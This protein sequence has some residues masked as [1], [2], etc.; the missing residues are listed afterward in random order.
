M[1]TNLSYNFFFKYLIDS[2]ICKKKELEDITVEIKDSKPGHWLLNLADGS[3]LVVKQEP[4]YRIHNSSNL[5]S[6][7]QHIYQLLTSY[8][9]LV[10]TSS[11]LPEVVHFDRE[12]WILVYKSLADYITLESYY[13][14]L[15]SES[16]DQTCKSFSTSVAELVGKSLAKLHLETVKFQDEY[17]NFMKEVNEENCL[18]QFPYQEYI[19]DILWH[20][21]LFKL[22]AEGFRFFDFYQRDDNLRKTVKHLVDHHQRCCLTHNNLQLNKILIPRQWEKRLSEY[23]DQN[24]L[25]LIDWERWNWGDP[26]CD[27]GTAIAGYLV[28]WL[29]SIAVHPAIKL[30]E[31]LQLATI[32]LEVIRPSMVVMIQTYMQTFSKVLE[33]RS[34][35]IKRVIQFAG[36]ALIYK[37]VENI[38]YHKDF[39]NQEICMLQVAKSLL[40]KPEKSLSSIFGVT[41]V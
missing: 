7:E 3:K 13:E 32:P 20:E 29:N 22:P 8:P 30:E 35:F 16:Y 40:C 21:S 25:Q 24:L 6:H 41:E 12:N 17:K 26:A 1:K 9:N 27:L 18:Y 31:S 39:N 38:L 14:A 11:L 34:D 23:S 2:N 33:E 36:L 15:S 28:L 5:T 19:L 37:I 10:N 4:A